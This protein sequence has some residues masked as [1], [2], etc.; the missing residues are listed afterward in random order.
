MQSWN[1]TSNSKKKMKFYN[2]FMLI[3]GD[4]WLK[5]PKKAKKGSLAP[6][7]VPKEG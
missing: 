1:I 2:H 7:D 6:A 5:V 4:F 3:S